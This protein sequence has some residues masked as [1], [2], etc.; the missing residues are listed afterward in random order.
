MST[1]SRVRITGPLVPYTAGFRA[2]LEAR[3]Y[4][5]NAVVCQLHVFAHMSRWLEAK[6]LGPDS[7]TPDRVR[8]FLRARR[9]A[10]YTMWL[11]DKGVA[12]VLGYLIQVG[13]APVPVTAVPA[14]TAEVVL[15]EF[16]FYLIH[17]RGL[18]LGTVT[19]DQHMARLFLATRPPEDPA[20]DGLTPAEVVS[21]VRDQCEERSAPYVTAG[22]R[23]FLRFCHLK[24]LTPRPLVGAVPKVASW[25][26][27]GLP[28][29]VDPETVRALL[30]GCDRRSTYGRR[31]YAV[32]MLLAGLGLRSGEVAGLRLE[33]I[34]WRTGEL[35]VRGKGPKLERLPLPEA[36]GGAIAA[37]LS[38]GRPRCSTREVITRVRAPH[39]PL[40]SSGIYAIV[41]A[42]CERAGV[43]RLHPHQLRHTA[44][45]EMLRA[46]ASLPEIGQVLRHQ[47]VLTTA[48]YAKVDRDRLRGLASPWPGEGEDR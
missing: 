19:A 41:T 38:R 45:T 44:A 24:G 17:E 10:G 1:P 48:I 7:L 6:R 5:P 2:D 39:G 13:A 47:S 29:A 35:V 43:S 21:F 3:G 37:W 14:T 11:S 15:D 28:K 18:A 33:D 34:D 12:Q 30:D 26:L 27:A 4:R 9:R 40:S 25:R 36:V 42:A 23:A 32:I 8:S 16:R 20:L 31:A 22:L 46:G